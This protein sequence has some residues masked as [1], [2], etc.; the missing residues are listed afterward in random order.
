VIG[1]STLLPIEGFLPGNE[2]RNYDITPDGKQFIVALRPEEAQV[3]DRP[4]QQINVVFNWF[5]ELRE[6]VPVK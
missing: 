2:T 4:I 6:R 3:A 5:T 1:K